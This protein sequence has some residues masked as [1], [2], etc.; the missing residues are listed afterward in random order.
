MLRQKTK[1]FFRSNEFK[2]KMNYFKASVCAII[3]GA[4]LSFII[5]GANALNPLL[6]FSYVFRLA[7]HPLLKNQTLTY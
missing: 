6:F 4:I 3:A 7:F 2:T 5:I 1:I